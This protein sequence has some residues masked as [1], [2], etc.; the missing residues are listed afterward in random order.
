MHCGC[1]NGIDN[2]SPGFRISG[3]GS[4]SKGSRENEFSPSATGGAIVFAVGW[5]S[6]RWRCLRESCVARTWPFST[7][8]D[9]YLTFGRS[10]VYS[11]LDASRTKNDGDVV[12]AVHAAQGRRTARR[13]M[14][15]N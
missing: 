10:V 8:S 11:T 6:V 15:E 2:T 12:R 9:A 13:Q 4:A 7:L 3:Y 5:R 14:G 1:G